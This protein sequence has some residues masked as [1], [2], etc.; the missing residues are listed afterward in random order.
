[1]QL[2]R[3]MRLTPRCVLCILACVLLQLPLLSFALPLDSP[4]GYPDELRVWGALKAVLPLRSPL[5]QQ[6]YPLAM[7]LDAPDVADAAFASG[8]D[9]IEEMSACAA[10]EIA[11]EQVYD[12]P[13][14]A[15]LFA[16]HYALYPTGTA[17]ASMDGYARFELAGAV[18]TAPDD[19]FYL[20]SADLE[21][22]GRVSDAQVLVQGEVP[23]GKVGTPLLVLYGCPS[24][25]DFIEMHRNVHAEATGDGA[26]FR[27]VWRHT[28]TLDSPAPIRNEFP[29]AL[30]LK[31]GGSADALLN[32]PLWDSSLL[33]S[34]F[35]PPSGSIASLSPPQLELLDIKAASLIANH[36]YNTRNVTSALRL[37]QGI[38]NN[39]PLVAAQ[40]ADTPLHTKEQEKIHTANADL[41][42]RGID[43]NLIGL[44]LNGQQLRLSTLDEYTLLSALTA[45]YTD[46][47]RLAALLHSSVSEAL[48]ERTARL[49]LDRYA[50][51]SLPH[52]QSS[53][54]GKVDLH[55]IPGFS[56]TVIYFNDIENDQQYAELGSDIAAFFEK[57]RFGEVPEY[58]QNWNEIVFA[59]D[60]ADLDSAN[61]RE[62]LAGL[63]RVLAVVSQGYPQRVGLLP[64][65]SG[66]AYAD[67]H[68]DTPSYAARVVNK[69][70][71]LKRMD[72]EELPKFLE[73]L[74]EK[75]SNVAFK[76]PTLNAIMN[77]PD[78]ARQARNLQLVETSLIV[79]GEIYPFRANT[80]NYLISNV[81][82]RDLEHIRKE[83][84]MQA[85]RSG[86]QSTGFVDVRGILH[87][88]S[89]TSR[90]LKYLPE[91]YADALYSTVDLDALM[92]FDAG[93]VVSYSFDTKYNVLH[94]VTLVGDFGKRDSLKR[95]GNLLKSKFNG[96]RIR[97]IHTGDVSCKTWKSLSQ[98][99]TKDALMTAVKD[100]L[101]ALKGSKSASG[102]NTNTAM[103]GIQQ[104]L[105]WLPDIPTTY[106]NSSAFMTLNGRFIHFEEDEVP[107]KRQFDAIVQREAIRTLNSIAALEDVY[108][109]F[110]SSPMSPDFVESQS[111]ILTR[112]YYHGDQIYHDGIK[113]TT[114]TVLPRVSL[115][116]VLK[117]NDFTIFG[118]NH[119]NKQLV[120]LL[121]II[122]PLEERTQKL[123]SLVKK[124]EKLDFLSIKVVLLPTEKLTINPIER[125]YIDTPTKIDDL[126][127]DI[128]ESF[129]VDCDAPANMIISENAKI[130]GVLLEV[131]VSDD[132]NYLSE[133][134]VDGVSGV[135][136]ELI[137]SN[138]VVVDSLYTM[139]TFGYGQ[140]HVS[141]MAANYTVRVGGDSPEYNL[142]GV[143]LYGFSDFKNMDNFDI[144]DFNPRKLYVKVETAAEETIR[145]EPTEDVNTNIFTVLEDVNEEESY[146]KMVLN[147]LSGTRK[148]VGPDQHFTFWVLDAPFLSS[149][150]KSFISEFNKRSTELKADIRL[151]RYEWP[152]WLRPQR[153]RHRRLSV[154]KLLFLDVLFPSNINHL[155]Y[156]SPQSNSIDPLEVLQESQNK[157]ASFS[158]FRMKGK[159]YWNEGYWK[160]MLHDNGLT[161]YSIEPAFVINLAGLRQSNAGDKLRLHYQ[162]LSTDVQSLFNIDQDLLNN[163][164]MEVP[165]GSLQSNL[166]TGLFPDESFVSEWL[167]KLESAVE[168]TT[169]TKPSH[170]ESSD[171]LEDDVAETYE[172][173]EL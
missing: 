40:L 44:F 136:L 117:E 97:L 65:N 3:L 163:I 78:Y 170:D 5:L 141:E 171:Y 56:E 38:A 68:S 83:L 105:Q 156:L 95:F 84:N 53:Q 21:K 135:H 28:C 10:I 166:R 114:E 158:L 122:D 43:Y 23:I 6:L 66:S 82:K 58:R 121:V 19:V 77:T 91:Y 42:K 109:S 35:T 47:Q 39:F 4:Y 110:S 173:D 165:L 25:P 89:T 36:Y 76:D 144:V 145:N 149:S 14:A 57:S 112:L 167:E 88:K 50:A 162:R 159:G 160:S 1:M 60:F 118:S 107:T 126:S 15:Q 8:I 151:V 119:N 55:R 164:Q 127:A 86:Q 52:L 124:F 37:A 85:A 59:V 116:S 13:A 111:S 142:A 17:P 46:M 154:S 140:F 67:P 48:D 134:Q 69:I 133:G 161:F 70:Y 93:R 31:D 125:V 100:S 96:I 152:N 29:L 24:S 94:T 92:Q 54:P 75:G 72:I 143:S 73:L 172:H 51:V 11:L 169:I 155:V 12:H 98:V 137:D 146:K 115:A 120:E 26:K 106:L 139:K 147:V 80:W 150:F 99:S 62:A 45:E 33:P 49:L 20:E 61:T 2:M 148:F 90:H 74:Q 7:G 64:L 63:A 81:L 27:F 9:D 168:S 113:F 103:L 157:K 108:P 101:K 132:K 104:L 128:L 129:E 34:T 153:F 123:L 41:A 79:N 71:D 131:F 18:H 16:L 22:Q 30:S 32:S 87:L 130:D 138:G 102:Q